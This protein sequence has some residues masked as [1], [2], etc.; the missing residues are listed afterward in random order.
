[1]KTSVTPAQ[2]RRIGDDV[3]RIVARTPVTDIHTHL[4]APAFRELLLSGLDELLVYHYLVAEAFRYFEMP[5]AEFWALPKARQAELIWDALFIQNSPVSESCRGV[6]TTLQ[7]LG[8]DVKKRDLPMLRRWFAK[9]KPADYVNRV[10]FNYGVTHRVGRNVSDSTSIE[11]AGGSTGWT[12]Q[13]DYDNNDTPSVGGDE[14]F[15]QS[16]DSGAPT[17]TVWN[18][19][20]T[21]VGIHWAITDNI[22]GTNEGESSIDTLMPEY[23]DSVN[24]VLANKSQSLTVVPEPSTVTLVALGLGGLLACR[25]LRPTQR[26]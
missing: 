18:G 22:P 10:L 2:A 21:L 1:M 4:Y 24:T 12:I 8:L 5:Y 26:R 17:F 13:F 14:T 7:H 25:R 11:T 15:L 19:Q 23:V 20:L 6:L 9:W 16:G 3:S